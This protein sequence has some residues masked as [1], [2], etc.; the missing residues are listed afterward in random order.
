MALY[1]HQITEP[2]QHHHSTDNGRQVRLL[3]QIDLVVGA[4]LRHFSSILPLSILIHSYFYFLTTICWF[5]LTTLPIVQLYALSYYQA[6]LLL[7][8][9]VVNIKKSTHTHKQTQIHPDTHNYIS[10]K[11]MFQKTYV[12]IIVSE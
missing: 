4:N 7:Y 11:L 5:F 10:K 3:R 12:F 2:H 8:W 1:Q 9:C 6:L